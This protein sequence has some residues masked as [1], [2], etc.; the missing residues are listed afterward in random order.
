MPPGTPGAGKLWGGRFTE[1]A[2][3]TAAR[4][5]ASLGFDRR[6]WSYDIAG[7]VAWAS[8]LRRAGL[9][10]EDEERTIVAGL[11]AVRAELASGRFVFRP[12]LEDIHT[13]VER[14]LTELAGPVGGKL[15]TGRSRNDQIALDERLYLRDVVEG[16]D[17]GMR[18]VQAALVERA[19]QTLA[20]PMP[21]Y[22]HLQRAQPVVLA[23]HLLAYVFM[24]QR[25][26]ERFRECGARANVLPLGSGALA[27]TGFPID[28]EA[29]ARDLGFT[30]ASPNSLDAVSDRD[31]LAEF[32]AA[33]AITG[34]HLSRLAADLTLWATAEFGF[35]EFSDA[36]ATGSSI[37][38]QKKNPDV[39]ELIRG[40]SGRL[41]GNLVALLT[42]LKGLPLAY[43]S[44]MQEDKEPFFDSV[45]T[46]EAILVVLPP[47]LASLTFRT[48]RMRAAA[49]EHF[50]TATDLA[51]YLVRKGLPFR[52]AHEVVGRVVLHASTEG[53]TLEALPLDALR[54][55]SSLIDTDVADA[56][57][58][59]ASLRARAVTGGTAPA[60]VAR[61][62]AIARAMISPP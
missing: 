54:R 29:L 52:E 21:G 1:G 16:A 38:P 44:D 55:F 25:D 42:T 32:L 61:A 34:V 30:A 47:M 7:S 48:E 58:V 31:Y 49:G 20:V 35:V 4:F 33:A 6:L 23:H 10:T 12:E 46:L 19:E 26:R 36:F 14:R 15:H 27:G 43:N 45:D 9:L 24:F 57:G 62:L 8:A 53:V 13:N 18:R 17:E 11:E 5:T 41:T 50:A 22:T 40:K 28:R 39:A 59:D 60:A 3:P 51:D 56:L 37:M 2:D